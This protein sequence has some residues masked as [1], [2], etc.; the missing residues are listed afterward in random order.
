MTIIEQIL[1]FDIE[2]VNFDSI[3]EVSQ[4]LT[5]KQHSFTIEKV[6]Q[7]SKAAVPIAIFVKSVVDC[8]KVMESVRPIQMALSELKANIRNQEFVLDESQRDIVSLEKE[9][10]N[11]LTS[12][13]ISSEELVIL[14]SEYQQLSERLTKLEE[15]QNLLKEQA[16]SWKE[17]SDLLDAY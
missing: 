12:L 8:C 13:K 2:R 16:I 11:I 4:I 9:E 17:S 1:D 5:K 15:I 14:E 7:I 10:E 3:K 6:Q